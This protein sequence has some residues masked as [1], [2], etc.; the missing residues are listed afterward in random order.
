M[1]TSPTGVAARPPL[2]QGERAPRRGRRITLGPFA[3]WGAGVVLAFTAGVVALSLVRN[4]G[5]L[6]YVIDDPAIHLSLAENLVHSGTWGLE[7][8]IFESAS[9]SP[10][11]T[12]LMAATAGLLPRF[13]EWAPLLVNLAA[14]VLLLAVLGRSQTLL[15]PGWRRPLDVAVVAAIALAVL[16]LPGL[17]A[18]GMEHT[19][20][21]ALVVLAV[22]RFTRI[23]SGELGGWDRTLTYLLLAAAALMRFETL[24]VAAGFGVAF[25]VDCLPRLSLDGRGRPFGPQ[26]VSGA[27]CGMAAGLPVLAVGAVNVAMGQSFW[28]N[29][30]LSKTALGG[31]VEDVTSRLLG[32]YEVVREIMENDPVVLSLVA[33]AVVVLV[34]GWYGGPRRLGFA[35]TAFLVTVVLHTELAQY[36]Y[37]ERYQA[38]LIAFG[39]YIALAW[40]SQV[41][42]PAGRRPVLV[43]ALVLILL[44][45][46]Y[47]L[48]LATGLPLA[49][50]NTYSQRYQAARFLEHYYDGRA[51]A[52]SELGY[53]SLLHHGPVVDLLGLGTHRV[54]I[55]RERGVVDAD[56]WRRLLDEENVEVIAAYPLTLSGD[57]VPENWELVAQ[58]K[59]SGGRITGPYS[60]FYFYAPRGAATDR[61]LRNLQE[62]D[63]ELPDNEETV[64]LRC[65][66]ELSEA[67]EGGS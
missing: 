18:I 1:R 35:A 57:E 39:V 58:W 12:L 63:R 52:T 40:G 62:F 38:Y 31:H 17:A 42:R 4:D 32:P 5:H 25:L 46:P 67:R 56:Y 60:K 11:W 54:V 61:L 59:L 50:N 13:G 47:K 6:V 65:L 48:K 7:R 14:A 49:M 27:L 45:S 64:C 36:G 44:I 29:S 51:V 37:V 34:W 22:D 15:R 16:F 3:T 26:V 21:A 23:R 28:P 9:S 8:G 10:G 30:V 33:L 55:A 41:V 66:R 19:L 43:T 2:T 53:V 20:H 24:F